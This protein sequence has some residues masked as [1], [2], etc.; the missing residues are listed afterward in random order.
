L[1]HFSLTYQS[2][3]VS[4]NVLFT[5]TFQNVFLTTLNSDITDLQGTILE[6]TYVRYEECNTINIF[7]A[8]F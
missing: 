2:T 6:Y 3:L 1:F 7:I 5:V 4:I 8:M